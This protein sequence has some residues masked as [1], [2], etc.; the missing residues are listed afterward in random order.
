MGGFLCIGKYKYKWLGIS[1]CCGCQCVPVLYSFIRRLVSVHV[2][3]V[4][5]CCVAMCCLCVQLV[6]S[7]NWLSAL[8]ILLIVSFVFSVWSWIF[9]CNVA[10]HCKALVLL[11]RFILRIDIPLQ[12]VYCVIYC[13]CVLACSCCVVVSSVL[14]YIGTVCLI[15]LCWKNF[16]GGPELGWVIV[17][18]VA[19]RGIRKSLGAEWLGLFC[20]YGIFSNATKILLGQLS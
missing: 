4:A 11:I 20:G 16:S 14:L 9:H 10:V 7:L 18:L 3:G 5:Q 6:P 13:M 19:G 17:L 12:Y 8:V 2:C 15:L 1:L